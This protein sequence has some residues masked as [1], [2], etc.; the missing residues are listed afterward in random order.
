[1]LI[2]IMYRYIIICNIQNTT[3]GILNIIN[4]LTS[5][6]TLSSLTGCLATRSTHSCIASVICGITEN[7]NYNKLQCIYKNHIN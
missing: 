5:G 1:M 7:H 3:R 6:S 2:I 4:S